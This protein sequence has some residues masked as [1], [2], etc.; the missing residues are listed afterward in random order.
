VD[1]V[2]ITVKKRDLP[3]VGVEVWD[4]VAAIFMYGPYIPETDSILVTGNA[5]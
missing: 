3:D 2:F 5:I 1:N 4:P